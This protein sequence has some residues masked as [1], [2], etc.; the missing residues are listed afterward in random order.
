MK[1]KESREKGPHALLARLCGRYTG[2]ARTWLEPGK[3][4]DESPITGEFREALGGRFIIH[5]YR[6]EM[7][8]QPLTG[9]ATIG[10]DLQ[11]EKFVTSWVDTYHTGTMI[12]QFIADRAHGDNGFSVLGSY[13]DPTGGPSW[14]WRIRTAIL[15]ADRL[16]IAHYNIPPGAEEALAIEIAYQRDE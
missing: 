6:G 14:G 4:A 10:F 15:D 9:I 5:E 3:L 2:I 8:K 13:P 16:L 7:E 1:F 11:A 12:M